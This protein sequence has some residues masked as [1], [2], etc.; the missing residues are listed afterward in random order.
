MVLYNFS[1]L[2]FIFQDLSST[3]DAERERVFLVCQ[4]IRI[5]RMDLKEVETKKQAK[6]MRR[7][8]G[9]AAIELTE[10]FHGNTDSYEE[11][12]SFIP[13]LQ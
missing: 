10:M 2:V 13:F 12:Q 1:N 4:I 11:K 3:Q 8:F 9:V 5:G 6:G 7:P